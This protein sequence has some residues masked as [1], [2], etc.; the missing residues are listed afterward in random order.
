[1]FPPSSPTDD[2]GRFLVGHGPR[3]TEALV[4]AELDALIGESERD[5]ELLARPIVVVVPSNSLRDHL[6]ARL[7]ARRGRSVAGVRI[8]TLH[9]LA[10]DIFARAGG[11]A[12]ASDVLFEVLV[13]RRARAEA[14]LRDRLDPLRDGYAAIVATVRD[15]LDAGF[16]GAQL[17]G[18]SEQIDELGRREGWRQAAARAATLVRIAADV[19]DAAHELGASAPGARWA[20]AEEA[21]A[22][23]P[24]GVLPARAVL[25]HGFADAT[26]TATDLLQALVVHRAA[27]VFLDDPRD[28]AEPSRID[29]GA[30]FCRRFRERLGAPGS[31]AAPSDERDP[32]SL[33][34]FR[35]PG[36]H[37]EAREIATRIRRLLDSGVAAE[38]IVVVARDLAPYALALRTHLGRLA[39]PF[40]AMATT[41][42]AGGVARRI[43][44]LLDLVEGGSRTPTDRWLELIVAPLDLR[45][46]L[47]SLGLVTLAAVAA[48]NVDAALDGDALP[49][50]LRRGFEEE[51]APVAAGGGGERG[52]GDEVS[53]AR[54][55]RALRRVLP[56]ALLE[57]AVTQ[58][59]R[60]IGAFAAWRDEAPAALHLDHLRRLLNEASRWDGAG[61]GNDDVRSALAGLDAELPAALP[62]T[63]EELVLVLRRRLADRGRQPLGGRGGGVQVLTVVEARG[64]TADHLFLLGV[65]R[66]VFPRPLAE[67]PLLPDAFRRALRVTLDAMPVKLEGHVEERYL[68]AQLAA[69]AEHVTVSWQSL[70][71]DGRDRNVSPLLERLLL[72]RDIGSED[73]PLCP[74]PLAATTVVGTLRPPL[75]HAIAAGLA[76]GRRAFRSVFAAVAAQT[77]SLPPAAASHRLAALDELDPPPGA[78]V[79]GRLGPFFGMVGVRRPR[80]D[81][82]GAAPA[83]TTLESIARCP[84]QAFLGTV[85]RLEPPR[86]PLERL[87]D[88][89]PLLVGAILHDTLEAL[90]GRAGATTGGRLADVETRSPVRVPW[91]T[92]DELDA[93]V[94]ASAR[95]VA[96]TNGVP[97]LAPALAARVRPFLELARALD[98]DPEAPAVLGAEVEG[99]VEVSDFTGAP[100]ALLFRADRVDASERGPVLTDYKTGRFIA[101]NKQEAIRRRKLVEAVL[102]GERLQAMAYALAAGGRGRYVFLHRPEEELDRAVRDVEISNDDR[103]VADAF[104]AAVAALLR[105]W[106]EGTFVPRLLDRTLRKAGP[107]CARCDLRAACLQGDSLA[108]RR[109]ARWLAAPSGET[110]SVAAYAARIV[111]DPEAG[112]AR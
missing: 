50:P 54:A 78:E 112:G 8:V 90:A 47:R 101:D 28:P 53:A 24:D 86:D 7:V 51:P 98:W 52:S 31:A 97:A 44:A 77:A 85:L 72:A 11:T 46:G 2:H 37:G 30:A 17:E 56:R 71:D 26:G 45:V 15:L 58:A 16:T 65:N 35:A 104:A 9:H 106:D 57:R 69:A 84:W 3:H 4:L 43:A 40:S 68:F 25:V 60:L 55:S 107:A 70:D 42:A 93:M 75:E 29:H 76:G 99:S 96:R 32:P 10:N 102:R 36:A 59:R 27:T 108:R 100:R 62:L 21:L 18:V 41:V 91:P 87:A 13:R 81:P 49:L 89:D 19:E 88:L 67:D 94:A 73:V 66:D 20:A 1:V 79:V 103:E 5:P 109:L 74:S 110:G 95:R 34:L 61:S 111:L 64:R 83:V 105:A 12:P 6:A 39:V 92:A 14:L 23:D 22:R 63:R 38:A 82:R 48:L 80:G 33:A